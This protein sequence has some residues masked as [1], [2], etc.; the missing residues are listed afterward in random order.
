MSLN[1]N[2]I[3]KRE[4]KLKP[5]RRTYQV[6]FFFLRSYTC[7]ICAAESHYYAIRRESRR[8]RIGF[9]TESHHL[10][11][12]SHLLGGNLFSRFFPLLRPRNES[13]DNSIM[14]TSTKRF[15]RNNDELESIQN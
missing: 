14:T 8:K 11:N 10:R 12:R 3:E 5:R 7:N 15:R 2:E 1:E 4:T 6:R 9:Y 13:R